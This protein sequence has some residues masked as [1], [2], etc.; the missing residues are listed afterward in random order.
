MSLSLLPKGINVYYQHKIS[1]YKK[2]QQDLEKLMMQM[3][4]LKRKMDVLD[5]QKQLY[6]R[7]N[8]QYP[9]YSLII[10]EICNAIPSNRI[11]LDGLSFSSG[12]QNKGDLATFTIRGRQN[13]KEDGVGSEITSFVLYLEQSGFFENISHNISGETMPGGA[14]FNERTEN[15]LIG[16]LAPGSGFQELSFTINGKVKQG[17]QFVVE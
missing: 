7:L 1:S 9:A 6:I 2:K 5:F 13:Q 15:N 8:E 14:D 11:V 12:Q 3:M 17:K 4:G 10:A 16:G